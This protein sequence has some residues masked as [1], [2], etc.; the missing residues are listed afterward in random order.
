VSYFEAIYDSRVIG[1]RG[2]TPMAKATS[3]RNDFG[4]FQKELHKKSKFSK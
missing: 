1:T 4:D 2:K 3:M